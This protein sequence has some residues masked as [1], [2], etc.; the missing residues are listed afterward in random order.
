MNA[1]ASLPGIIFSLTIAGIIHTK[2]GYTPVFIY[3]IPFY[4][5]GGIIAA[6]LLIGQARP[7]LARA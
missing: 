4:V 1:L 7:F 3:A 2:Y 6:A 5:I